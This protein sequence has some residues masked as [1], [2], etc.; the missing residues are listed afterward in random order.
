MPKAPQKIFE[1]VLETFG[2]F[3]YKSA[4]NSCFWGGLGRH[5]SN[6]SKKKPPFFRSFRDISTNTPQKY[7]FQGAEDSLPKNNLGYILHFW[8][9]LAFTT[10]RASF[11]PKCQI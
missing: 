4:M 10:K 2:K 6:I 9:I 8:A 7:I 11:D 5:M 1:H 3:V